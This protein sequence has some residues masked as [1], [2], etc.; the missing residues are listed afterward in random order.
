[1]HF[2]KIAHFCDPPALLSFFGQI[3]QFAEK[4]L[5]LQGSSSPALRSLDLQESLGRILPLHHGS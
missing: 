3:P 4:G 1:M 2:F 5:T